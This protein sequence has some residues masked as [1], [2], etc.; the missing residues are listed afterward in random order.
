MRFTTAT[1]LSLTLTSALSL[2]ALAPVLAQDGAPPGAGMRDP[3]RFTELDRN[4]DGIVT[5]EEFDQAR[6]ERRAARSEAGAPMRGITNAPEFSD[7]DQDGD[8]QLTVEEFADFRA[9]RMGS[10]GGMGPGAGMGAGGMGGTG[11]GR[12]MGPGQG[13]GPGMGRMG[14]QMP[15]FASFDADGDGMLSKDEFETGRAERIKERSQQGYQM[16]N[17]A[18]APSFEDVDQNGDGQIDKEEFESAQMQQRKMMQP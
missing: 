2:S 16:R 15:T 5:E 4:D 13:M 8:G 11:Q 17:L 1:T 14:G 7:I 6:S 18:N 3:M 9:Q 10:R 12:G